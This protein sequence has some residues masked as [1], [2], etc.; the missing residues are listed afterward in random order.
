MILVSQAKPSKKSNELTAIK[1]MVVTD[2]LLEPVV[3]KLSPESG[4]EAGLVAEAPGS[5][6]LVMLGITDGD[7]AGEPFALI[8]KQRFGSHARLGQANGVLLR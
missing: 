2:T 5:V 6:V 8:T 3:I 4:D 1:A 7:G